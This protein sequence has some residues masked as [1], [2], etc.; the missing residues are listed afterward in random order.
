MFLDSPLTA[1]CEFTR[2][3]SSGC[4]IFIST[5]PFGF[6]HSFSTTKG[7]SD[8]MMIPTKPINATMFFIGVLSLEVAL[9]CMSFFA[10]TRFLLL[11]R[12][13]AYITASIS[14]AHNRE[15]NQAVSLHWQSLL[16]FVLCP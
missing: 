6:G 3:P 10:I 11:D 9:F 2:P 16:I 4:L 5:S 14:R 12:D 7:P 13:V 1:S 15:R 8:V